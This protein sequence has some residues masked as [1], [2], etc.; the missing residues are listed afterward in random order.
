MSK[1]LCKTTAIILRLECSPARRA[2]PLTTWNNSNIRHT[3][4]KIYITV[5]ASTKKA[6]PWCSPLY[7]TVAT[8]PNNRFR[9]DSFAIKRGVYKYWKPCLVVVLSPSA[10]VHV[11]VALT[12]INASSFKTALHLCPL[13]PPYIY[14]KLAMT[15]MVML[16][17]NLFM[18]VVRGAYSVRHLADWIMVPLATPE[19]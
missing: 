6:T 11:A 19:R 4:L 12:P 10:S 15:S 1:L 9:G 13:A 18:F 8:S 3:S 2:M 7:N 16:T 14:I 5:S 17:H